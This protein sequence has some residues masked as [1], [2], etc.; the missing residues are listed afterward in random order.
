[1]QG[2]DTLVEEFRDYEFSVNPGWVAK[3][4]AHALG[5]IEFKHIRKEIFK[6]QV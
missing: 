3:Y 4:F 6:V 5:D 2:R 1:M